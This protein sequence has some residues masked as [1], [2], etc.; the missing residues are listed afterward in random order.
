MKLAEASA[1]RIFCMACSCTIFRL[2]LAECS[3]QMLTAS[4]MANVSQ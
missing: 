3:P 4:T 1:S 2:S